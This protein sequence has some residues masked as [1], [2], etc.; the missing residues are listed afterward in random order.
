MRWTLH[1]IGS[2]AAIILLACLG[3]GIRIVRS[4]PTDFE[5]CLLGAVLVT[6]AAQRADRKE[7][8]CPP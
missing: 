5:T 8:E 1:F 4:K 3:A 6:V 7:K 2:V